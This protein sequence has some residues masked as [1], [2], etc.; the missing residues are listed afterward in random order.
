[1][2]L[3]TLFSLSTCRFYSIRFFSTYYFPASSNYLIS[4]SISCSA[5]FQ[6]SFVMSICS[7]FVS[8][9]MQCHRMWSVVRFTGQKGHSG[10]G[11]L[12]ITAEWVYPVRKR[13][14]TTCS[15]LLIVLV[16]VFSMWCGFRAFMVVSFPIFL[17]V[18]VHVFLLSMLSSPVGG[19]V[20]VW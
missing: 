5:P 2:F 4:F 16:L 20:S 14:M 11:P 15:R 10:L 18:L 1:M 9:P 7:R 12:S 17:V 19:Y 3:L 8:I 6:I 13:L